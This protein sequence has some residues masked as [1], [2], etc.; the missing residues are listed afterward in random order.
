VHNR[1]L[2]F[3]GCHGSR[4]FET[5]AAQALGTTGEERVRR[6]ERGSVRF[7]VGA[8]WIESGG[9]KADRITMHAAPEQVTLYSIEGAGFKAFS[10]RVRIQPAY[11]RPAYDL[12]QQVRVNFEVYADGQ[13]RAQSGLMA[14]ADDARL[15]VADGLDG[16]REL[17]LVTRYDR[18][19]PKYAGRLIYVEWQ[20]AKCYK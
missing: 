12:P 11:A 1:A 7:G 20:E 16:V 4:Q 15:L 14:P 10:V 9:A 2:S 6:R 3:C 13:L 5:R 17:K 19:E 8:Y 18:P